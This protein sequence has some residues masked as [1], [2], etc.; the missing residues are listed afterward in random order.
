MK[1]FT[2]FLLC[3]PVS[4]LVISADAQNV[5]EISDTVY[6]EILNEHRTIVIQLPAKY[7][8]GSPEVYDVIYI[9]DGKWN[10]RHFSYIH[11]FAMEDEFVPPV[12]LV[13]LPNTYI[14]GQN[15]RDRDFSKF[16]YFRYGEIPEEKRT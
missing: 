3:I 6:S 12:I 15:M 2:N 8:P 7:D 16:Q 13:L 5:S 11:G 14:D 9:T 4:I 10:M 1:T